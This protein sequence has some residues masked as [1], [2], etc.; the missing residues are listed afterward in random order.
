MFLSHC[1][2][3]SEFIPT[4]LGTSHGAALTKCLNSDGSLYSTTPS[5]RNWRTV[6]VTGKME[7]VP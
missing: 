2:L 7:V 5:Q 1:D 4:T 3:T 6:L